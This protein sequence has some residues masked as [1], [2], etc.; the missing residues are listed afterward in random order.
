LASARLHKNGT[1]SMQCCPPSH[2]HHPARPSLP[3]YSFRLLKE[4]CAPKNCIRKGIW[5]QQGKGGVGVGDQCTNF[6][7]PFS[8]AHLMLA[9][10]PSLLCARPC[11]ALDD[12]RRGCST[13][14]EMADAWHTWGAPCLLRHLALE[15]GQ[16][17]NMCA[18]GAAQMS[19]SLL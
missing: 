9:T 14:R 1:G 7:L 3:P 8:F 15:K 19:L 10:V 18:L 12:P 4:W 5:T 2:S 6:N 17:A 13:W 16:D 11:G